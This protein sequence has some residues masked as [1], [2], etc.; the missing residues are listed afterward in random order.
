[1]VSHRHHASAALPLGGPQTRSGRRRGKEKSLSPPG[2]RAKIPR[3]LRR[4]RSNYV[5][6]AGGS[7]V[8]LNSL[9]FLNQIK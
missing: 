4:C 8:Y 2:N 6:L 3:S 7:A 1:M 5:H 9:D